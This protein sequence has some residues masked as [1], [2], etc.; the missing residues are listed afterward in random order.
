L[1]KEEIQI[2]SDISVKKTDDP[3]D[4]EGYYTFTDG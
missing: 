1:K 3:E 2:I 4:R